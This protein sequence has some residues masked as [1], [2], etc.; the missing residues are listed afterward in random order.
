MK[1]SIIITNYNYQDYVKECI[2]SCLNQTYKNIE[3]I[4]VDDGSTDNSRSVLNEYEDSVKLVF[5]ENAGMVQ[6]SNTGYAYATGDLIIFLDA[7][8]FLKERA[9]ENVVNV[10]EKDTVKIHF[11]LEKQNNNGDILGIVPSEGFNLSEGDVW[12]EIL[13]RGDYNNVP[14]SG[15]VYSKKILDQIFPILGSKIGNGN[16]YLDRFPTDSFLKYRIPFYGSVKA[17]QEP[18]GVYRVHGDNNGYKVS[19]YL[20][21]K[22]RKRIL[23][24][25]K[26]NTDFINSKLNTSNFESFYKRVRIIRCIALS[27]RLEG[28]DPIWNKKNKVVLFFK[29]TYFLIISIKFKVLSLCYNIFFVFLILFFSEKNLSKKLSKLFKNKK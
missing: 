17:I 9:L 3:I 21:D 25:A 6:A 2:D 23:S 15:N 1:V 8:D 18:M 28:Y 5:Q 14:T 19:S 7:D 24:I 16:S 22:K 11:K 26:M 10:C 20:N 13:K 27:Y 29:L 4:V 12:S